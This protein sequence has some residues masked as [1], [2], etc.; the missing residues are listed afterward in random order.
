[1]ASLDDRP[2]RRVYRAQDETTSGHRRRTMR[3]S[4]ILA[5][6]VL[7][8]VAVVIIV[9]GVAARGGGLAGSQNSGTF[10]LIPI[11]TTTTT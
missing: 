3:R 4:P 2:E 7:I 6:A 9:I 11:S 10:R 5:I 8:A 1:M